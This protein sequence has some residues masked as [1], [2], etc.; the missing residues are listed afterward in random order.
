MNQF[1]IPV[2]NLNFTNILSS[3]SISPASFYHKRGYGFKRF[4]KISA[5]PFDNYLLAYSKIPLLDLPVNDRDEFPIYI[6]IDPEHLEKYKFIEISNKIN[7]LLIDGPVY[8][9][10]AKSSFL[11][12]NKVERDKL[13]PSYERSLEVKFA[14]RYYSGIRILDG[15]EDAF[16]WSPEEIN[17]ISDRS[18]V[19]ET[20]LLNDQLFNK[21]RGFIYGYFAGKL[22]EQPKEITRAKVYFQEFI[23]VLSGLMNEL[24]SSSFDNKKSLPKN[25][26]SLNREIQILDDLREKLET[27]VLNNQDFNPAKEFKQAFELEDSTIEDLKRKNY[28]N[29]SIYEILLSILK[30]DLSDQNSSSELLKLLMSKLKRFR[31]YHSSKDY[32]DIEELF[33]IV[34]VKIKKD[35]EEMSGQ[36]SEEK[37]FKS[38]PL[39]IGRDMNLNSISV[40]NFNEYQNKLYQIVINELLRNSTISTSDEIGQSRKEII[41][42][43]GKEIKALNLETNDDLKYLRM[44]YQSLNKLGT[45]FKINDTRA[46]PLQALAFFISRYSEN[47]KLKDMMDKNY[48]AQQS[49]VF[50]VWGATYG[51]ANT[52]K[53]ILEPLAQN[54]NHLKEVTIYIQQLLN[55]AT[56]KEKE[57][58]PSKVEEERPL[59]T[60]SWD[61]KTIGEPVESNGVK[62]KLNVFEDFLREEKTFA[63]REDWINAVLKCYEK[64]LRIDYPSSIYEIRAFQDSLDDQ[65]K[66]LKKFGP[67]KVQLATEILEKALENFEEQNKNVVSHTTN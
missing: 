2:S 35:I 63:I 41:E 25:N 11:V 61:L 53:F 52:S 32:K 6:A 65:K 31:D 26:S 8:I 27:L 46:V 48:F 45:G 66:H 23:N 29:Q 50:G 62:T 59:H 56:G 49:L 17:S 43:V 47:E 30:N 38:L 51:Y 42:N 3:E 64:V 36:T 60:Q 24:S 44:L 7:V 9:N 10:W 34:R 54:E 18:T 21:L 33:Q 12:R 40:D 19:N 58:R 15:T 14:D 20:E 5:N 57:S 55:K 1:Y 37:V 28:K 16:I 39:E 13:K 67:K 4:E 22:N